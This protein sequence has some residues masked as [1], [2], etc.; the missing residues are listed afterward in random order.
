MLQELRVERDSQ[1]YIVL[2]KLR[3]IRK[4]VE[5]DLRKVFGA[6]VDI[7]FNIIA[8]SRRGSG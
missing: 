4:D 3:Y 5:W 2:G 6:R 8:G 1:K 7:R